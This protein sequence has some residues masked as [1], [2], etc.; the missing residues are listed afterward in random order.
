MDMDKGLGLER[1]DMD[2]GLGLV[3]LGLVTADF[4]LRCRA[5]SVAGISLLEP[6]PNGDSTS[7][8]ISHSLYLGMGA[9][10]FQN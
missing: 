5:C 8:H 3:T 10:H 1:M 7:N 6:L 9:I 2:K 4:L